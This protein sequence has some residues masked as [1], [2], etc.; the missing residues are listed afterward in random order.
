MPVPSILYRKYKEMPALNIT[1]VLQC[2][3]FGNYPG[4]MNRAAGQLAFEDFSGTEDDFLRTLAR[5]EWGDDADSVVRAWK[6]FAEGFQH[7]PLST[8]FQG[9]ADASTPVWPLHLS[10]R[11][12]LPHVAGQRSRRR[13]Q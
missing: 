4:V 2:W 10:R 11:Q 9:R 6:H 5:S 3:Y 7:F 8:R 1:S 12:P 13:H